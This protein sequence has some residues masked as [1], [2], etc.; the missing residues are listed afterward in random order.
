M[1]TYNLL[2]NRFFSRNALANVL[3]K[4]NAG[5]FSAMIRTYFPN[6]V[7]ATKAEVFQKTYHHLRKEYRNEYYF[8]NTLLN[9]LLINRHR[10][11]TTTALTEVP[12]GK[13]VA[14]IIMINGKAQVYE[15]KTDL[16]NIDRIESQISDYYKAF[17]HVSV[18]TCEQR[19]QC[20]AA[21]IPS[22]VGLH[23]LNKRES[24][25]TIREPIEDRSHLDLQT[26][27]RIMLKSEFEAV[28]RRYYP[29]PSVTQFEYYDACFRLL[30]ALNINT[31]YS[32]FLEQLKSRRKIFDNNLFLQVPEELRFL[33][34]FSSY[35][36]AD[37]EKLQGFLSEEY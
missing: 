35:K 10:V 31:V 29:L 17:D 5:V 23:V 1:S 34:Y 14:D 28:V 26:I 11:S 6:E 27:F 20:I 4:T 9:K 32:N 15:I 21:V 25:S 36:K 22:T 37:Y 30:E 16:D 19:L 13:S 3:D 2:L 12:I 24:I 8:K 33:V 7:F 18:V